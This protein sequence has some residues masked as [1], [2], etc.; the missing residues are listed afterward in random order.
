V[1]ES[2]LPSRVGR[3]RAT[4]SPSRGT[5]VLE[6]RLGSAVAVGR[7]SIEIGIYDVQG[8]LVRMLRAPVRDD[9]APVIWDGRDTSGAL[10]ASGRY[11]A[12]LRENP[13]G[14]VMAG[15]AGTPIVILR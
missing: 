4:P 3:L 11:W 13:A 12:R 1:A 10:V 5:V 15:G 7:S 9:V 14:G 2:P 6:A 8:R